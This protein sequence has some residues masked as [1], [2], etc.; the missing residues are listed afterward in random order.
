M[1]NTDVDNPVSIEDT[2]VEVKDTAKEEE[3]EG[4]AAGDDDHALQ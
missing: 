4:F 2:V 3:T 1:N